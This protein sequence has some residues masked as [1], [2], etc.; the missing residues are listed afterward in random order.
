[1]HVDECCQA[2]L[3]H[4]LPII[5]KEREGICLDVGVGTFNFYCELFARLGFRTTAVEPLPVKALRRICRRHSITLIEGCLSDV[6]GV[7]TLYIGTFQGAENIN[8]SSLV[9]NWWGAGTKTVDVL[10]MTLARLLSTI[11]AQRVTCLKLDIEGMEFATVRQLL[12]LPRSLLPR[13]VVLEYGG[14]DSKESG[15]AGWSPQFFDATVQCL[16]VLKNRGYS[17]SI[18]IDSS[19]KTVERT[20][21]LAS[22]NLESDEIFPNS[23]I[24]GNI[25][26]LRDLLYPEVEIAR[27]CS[28]YRDNDSP[29]P[30]LF[31]RDNYLLRL[32]RRL[33]KGLLK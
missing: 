32:F 9:P 17:F 28:P 4:I 12:G 31:P 33:Y 24:Y 18:F 13:V 20:L 10:A 23:A 14:G 11:R 2:L 6:D 1:M 16:A 22:S 15:R 19:P 21:D 3:A 29:P 8:V 30:E 27:I 25:V 5:D 26:S 7:Q